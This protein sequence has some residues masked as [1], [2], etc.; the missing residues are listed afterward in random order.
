MAYYAV[1][2]AAG[3]PI[4]KKRSVIVSGVNKRIKYLGKKIVSNVLSCFLKL[5]NV[6]L[7]HYNMKPS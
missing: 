1:K 6:F 5:L 3:V 7:V 2:A 4:P